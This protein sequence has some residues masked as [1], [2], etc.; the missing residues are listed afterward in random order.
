MVVIGVMQPRMDLH[1]DKPLLFQIAEDV[2]HVARTLAGFRGE[3][4]DGWPALPLII[5]PIREGQEGEQ[6][7]ALQRRP[8]PDEGHNGDAHG[9]GS[10]AKTMRRSSAARCGGVSWVTVIRWCATSSW[11]AALTWPRLIPASCAMVAGL[12]QQV[13]PVPARL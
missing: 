6:G 4:G 5:G 9:A 1:A 13:L 10:S 12:H 8:V 2:A 3:F 7:A 11:V